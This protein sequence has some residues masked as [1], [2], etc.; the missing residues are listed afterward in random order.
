MRPANTCMKTGF[1]KLAKSF[2]SCLYHFL[3]EF[4]RRLSLADS[5]GVVVDLTRRSDNDPY[6]LSDGTELY[7]QDRFLL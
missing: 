1:R 2:I 6:L 3:L 7:T 5:V 4:S